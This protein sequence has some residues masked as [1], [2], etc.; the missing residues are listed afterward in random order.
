VAAPEDPVIVQR[1]GSHLVVTLNRPERR[2]A[3]GAAVRDGLLAAL[4]VAIHDDSIT[5]VELRGRGEAFCSGGD[6]DEFGTASDVAEAYVVRL[7]ASAGAAVHR[8]RARVV[9]RVHGACIGAGIEVPAFADRVAASADAWFQLPEL[10]MGLVPG[11][12]GTVS[13]TR[14]IGRWRTAYLA[15]SGRPVDAATA[16]EWGLV[17]ELES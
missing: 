2:N 14:R 5:E 12:G 1:N 17:D 6:L 4:D 8:L 11:A 13:I 10:S 15:L 3:F 16:L 9:P 7:V